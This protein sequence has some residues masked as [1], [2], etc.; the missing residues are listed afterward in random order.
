[1]AERRVVV[2]GMGIV[3]PMGNNL[4]A[5]WQNILA[6]KSGIS[7]ISRFDPSNLTVQIAGEVKNFDISDYLP[8]KDARKYDTFVHYGYAAAKQAIDD[9]G[10]DLEK[11]DPTRM[12]CAVGSGIGGLPWII[13]GNQKLETAGQRRV[14]PF[15]IPGGIINMAAGFLSIQF[16][17]K[18]PSLAIV[19]ACTTGTHSIGHAARM[20]KY[21]DA[22]VMVAGGTEMAT[23]PIG[24]AGFAAARALSTRNDEPLR[25]SRPWDK[26]RDGFVL[27]EGAGILILEE[28]EHAK[29][30][31]AKIYAELCGFGMS[32][33]AYHMTAL[34]EGGE[35]PKRSMLNSLKDAGISPD[36]VDYINAH[37]TSTPAGDVVEARSVKLAFGDHAKV[38]SISSTK[39]MTG[40][41][42][43]A[44]GAIEAIFTV[45]SLD[46]Q[47]VP[48]TINLEEPDEG[49]DLDFVAGAAKQRPVNVAISNSF[50]FGG[51]NG[52]LVFSK[53]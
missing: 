10:L 32:S 16:N 5:A 24:V 4:K 18:G 19:S 12:G 47:V 22:E 14:S 11:E 31:G 53:I 7:R 25:A 43:G 1:M 36:K 29:K 13:D 41:L 46:D 28:Y 45:K 2:T 42:L 23:C 30:R 8:L 6:G 17:L 51:T 27:G 50:G 37:G 39:S 21:G 9:A 49:C 34:D 33:D 26:G 20:I 38:L 3:S 44:A 35:G 48:P 40:H 52:T 15:Y